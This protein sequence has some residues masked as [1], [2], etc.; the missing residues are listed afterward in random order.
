M[1]EKDLIVRLALE[2]YDLKHKMGIIREKADPIAASYYLSDNVKH[3]GNLVRA[4]KEMAVL[5]IDIV[6]L[7]DSEEIYE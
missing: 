3:K 7:I 5:G 1:S 2:L 4:I 6:N